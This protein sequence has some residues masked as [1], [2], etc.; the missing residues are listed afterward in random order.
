MIF[1]CQKCKSDTLVTV[2]GMC[3]DRCVVEYQG[4]VHG[5]Y[6]P[7]ELGIGEKESIQI[8]FC[9]I[10]GYIQGVFPLEN[11]LNIFCNFSDDDEFDDDI[12]IL[13]S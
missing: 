10:C 6:L 2:K 9:S 11:I 1:L 7:Q 13:Q 4:M 8:K 12:L 5:G 3:Y